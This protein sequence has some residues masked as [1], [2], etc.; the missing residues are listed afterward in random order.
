MPGGVPCYRCAFPGETMDF[1]CE[2][3]G[4][5]EWLCANC[6]TGVPQFLGQEL[7]GIEHAGSVTEVLFE[8]VEAAIYLRS[9]LPEEG[10][11]LVCNPR[12]ALS[13]MVQN[14]AGIA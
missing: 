10:G 9:D 14:R 6:S 5:V 11:K 13:A 3:T 12:A 4:K 1:A 8:Q 2:E 7:Q